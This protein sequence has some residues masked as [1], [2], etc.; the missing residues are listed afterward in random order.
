MLPTIPGEW[1]ELLIAVVGGGAIFQF[2][3]TLVTLVFNR[4]KSLRD[5]LRGE[6]ARLDGQITRLGQHIDRLEAEIEVYKQRVDEWRTKYFAL[7]EAYELFKIASQKRIAELET[8]LQKFIS[9][10]EVPS[11]GEPV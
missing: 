1:L 8:A 4:G 6:I 2:L 11:D 5:E 10:E 3:S 7:F 9:R